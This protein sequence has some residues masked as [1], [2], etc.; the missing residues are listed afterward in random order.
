LR[1][2]RLLAVA[3][4]AAPL[5]R[6][7]AQGPRSVTLAEAVALAARKDPAVIQAE[8]TLRSAGAAVRSA[9]GA[10][11]P[12]ITGTGS[13]GSSFSDGPARTDPI[14]GQLLP[15]GTKSQSAS[16]G[17]SG[18]LE[19]F[20]GFRRNA[21]VKSARGREDEADAAH[22]D[23]QAQSALRT[24]TDF[25][26]ALAS[27]EL[28]AVRQEGVRRAEEQLAVAVSKLVTRAATVA[29]SLRAVVQ[30]GEARLQLV[31]EAAR[32]AAAEA[33]LARRLG[34]PGRV[35]AVSDSGLRVPGPAPDTAAIL[36]EAVAR[37]PA[38]VRADAAARAAEAAYSA[39]KAGYWP[40]LQLSGDYAF[41]GTDRNDF[42][43]YNNRR[44]GLGLSWPLFN[45]FQR[46]QQ[47]VERDAARETAAA[48]ASDARREVEANLAAQFANLDAAQQRLALTQ[49][50]L[51][52]ARA[53]VAVAFERYRLG[54]ITI[55][56]LSQSQAGL[57]RAEENA[58]SARFE[59]LR[60]KA[61]IEA[62]LGRPL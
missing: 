48:R 12:A 14:T 37:A 40:R 33:A 58:V 38:V 19:I 51:E 52:A 24:S 62:I 22:R 9:R 15:G 3:C 16:F 46:E 34:M 42:S 49:L 13:G 50:S 55:T 2:T 39:A 47:I 53:D 29:D 32:L 54:S 26:N 31:S 17:L 8:G 45:R 6:A 56:D 44:I 5:P 28:V 4:L 7:A 23:A 21:D 1:I 36:T 27:R 59:Y 10:Y 20:A 25:F 18:D 35:T 61:E 41:S 60:A 11:L 43:M 30:L 57:T